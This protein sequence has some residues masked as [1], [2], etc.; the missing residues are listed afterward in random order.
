[1][2]TARKKRIPK[3][4]QRQIDRDVALMKQRQAAFGRLQVVAKRLGMKAA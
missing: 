1:M 4:L 3:W 2:V